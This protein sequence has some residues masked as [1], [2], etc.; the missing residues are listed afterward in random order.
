[1]DQE[2]QKVIA[3]WRD[4]ASD[5]DI[6]AEAPYEFTGLPTRRVLCIAYVPDFG[7]R[8]GI[9]VLST[10]APDDH[11]LIAVAGA[12][13]KMSPEA[14]GKYDRHEWIDLLERLRWFGSG[15]PP[16]W[17][18]A[19]S[20]WHNDSSAVQAVSEEL[21]RIFGQPV[22]VENSAPYRGLDL[23]PGEEVLGFLARVPTGGV[24]RQ[25]F[26]RWVNDVAAEWNLHYPRRPSNER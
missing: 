7:S 10:A 11:A 24:T 26:W 5:L 12:I 13:V 21:A 20:P 18:T 8:R 15:A 25:S 14:Y 16:P 22:S 6:R 4:A 3:A 19:I 2:D 23:L 1:M 9:L 17:Y